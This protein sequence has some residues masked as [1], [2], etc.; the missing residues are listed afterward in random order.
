M[1]QDS[2]SQ[3]VRFYMEPI[4]SLPP[5]STPNPYAT[6]G[7]SALAAF[8]EESAKLLA[9]TKDSAPNPAYLGSQ[10]DVKA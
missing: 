3:A 5:Q 7:A 10:V 1:T 2:R 6:I 4:T 9:M 8:E